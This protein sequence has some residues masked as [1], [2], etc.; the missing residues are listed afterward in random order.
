MCEQMFEAHT[1]QRVLFVATLCNEKNF[2]HDDK[3]KSV[4]DKLKAN[5]GKNVP[6]EQ[7]KRATI[8][9]K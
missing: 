1:A 5:E 3:G 4:P 6:V 8:K 7:R 2:I 9:H